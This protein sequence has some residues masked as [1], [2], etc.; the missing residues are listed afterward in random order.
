MRQKILSNFK[1]FLLNLFFP[2]FCINC[3]REGTF[4]CQ[5]CFSLLNINKDV[6]CPFC[7][8]PKIVL[9]GKTC[10]RCR[11]NK[12][13]NGLFN[14]SSYQDFIV[15]K[16]ILKFKYPPFIKELAKP[17]AFLIIQYLKNLGKVVPFLK[18]KSNFVFVPL[19]LHKKRLKWRGFNQAGE[20][21]KELSFYFKIPLVDDVLLKIKNTE[22]QAE[23]TGE[24]REKNIKNA[25][26][27]Q[28]P[29]KIKN[30]K[31][32]L[33]DDVFTTGSTMEECAKILKEAG[34]KEVWG[35]VVARE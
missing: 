16:M 23:L 27:V 2:A 5:D 32:L 18:D 26:F 33:V 19:P 25:F 24:E 6:F 22:N 12:K 10:N 13:L 28:N 20:I 1:I 7:K 4:L 29:E 17:L 11:K 21:A 9:D 14:A 8:K 31:I 3:Q 30:K 35:I 34:A 15:K